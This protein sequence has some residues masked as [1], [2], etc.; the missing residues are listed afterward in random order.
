M[1]VHTRTPTC[2]L[3]TAAACTCFV[4]VNTSVASHAQ[5]EN[6]GKAAGGR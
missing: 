2:T 5:D 4:H 6:W 3:A 1:W